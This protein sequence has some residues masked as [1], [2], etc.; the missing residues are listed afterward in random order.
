MDFLRRHVFSIACV[1]VA[2][3]GIA[4]IVTGVRAMPRVIDEMRR[5]EGLQRNLL[6]IE[7]QPVNLEKIEAAETQIELVREDRDKVFRK[8]RELYGYELLVPK[9]LPEGDALK[10]SDF[11][12]KYMAKMEELFGSLHCGRPADRTDFSVYQDQIEAEQAEE[13]AGADRGGSG[14]SDVFAGQLETLAGVKTKA[15]ARVDSRARA[16]IAV[17]Q[18][19]YMYGLNWKD[20]VLPD[21]VS[22][23][24][25]SI[26]MRDDTTADVPD[27]EYIWWAQIGYWVQKDVVGAI[28]SLNNERAAQI[29]EDKGSPWVGNLPVKELISV[30]LSTG[31]IPA[32]AEDEVFGA[33]PGGYG[34]ALPPGN[35]ETVFTRSGQSDEYDVIQYSVKLVMDVRDIP[36]LVDRICKGSFHTLLRISYEAVPVNRK[37]VGKIYGSGPVVNVVMDFETI[38][39]GEVFRPLLPEFVC[40][41]YGINCPERTEGEE[42]D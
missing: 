18:K 5:V 4:L 17:A 13:K 29:L 31:F 7:S 1:L 28:A 15:G 2:V 39:L 19:L 14:G 38:L 42:G 30:R 40:E 20:E 9:V 25:V 36:A 41:E 8:A 27:L 3:G 33:T 22:S 12:R 16:S 10:R 26:D 34:E 37:M 11:R 23:L 32:D 24:E 35:P 21:K 6:K